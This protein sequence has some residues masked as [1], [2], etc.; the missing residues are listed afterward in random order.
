[1]IPF[2]AVLND[3][4]SASTASV[5][6]GCSAPCRHTT[7]VAPDHGLDVAPDTALGVP[8]MACGAAEASLS[9]AAAGNDGRRFGAADP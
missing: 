2:R 4:S 1:M 6:E 5:Q 3:R 8:T 9:A 7:A